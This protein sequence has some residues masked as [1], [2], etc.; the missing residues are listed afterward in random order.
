MSCSGTKSSK[1]R[2]GKMHWCSIHTSK[3]KKSPGDF[4]ILLVCIFNNQ[5]FYTA[6]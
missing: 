2:M 5:A 1:L 4:F 6:D 3:I